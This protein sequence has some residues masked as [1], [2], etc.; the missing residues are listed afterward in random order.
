M[1]VANQRKEDSDGDV[2]LFYVE[3]KAVSTFQVPAT[4][5]NLLERRHGNTGCDIDV[6]E[7]CFYSSRYIYWYPFV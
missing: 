7:L 2:V 3:L 1:L 5:S 4:T 6:E